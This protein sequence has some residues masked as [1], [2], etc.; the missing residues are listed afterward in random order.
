MITTGKTPQEKEKRLI[1]GNQE[2]IDLVVASGRDLILIETKAY[3]RWDD[4]QLESKLARLHLVRNQHEETAKEAADRVC[5]Y[6]L[7]MSPNEGELRKI[8]DNWPEWRGKDSKVP[9]LELRLPPVILE[10][11]RCDERGRKMAN[12]NWWRIVEH[13]AGKPKGSKRA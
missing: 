6:F 13:G 4:E 1:E 8:N 9:W 12:N 2:D 11:S 7:L 5:M 10:V 3:G